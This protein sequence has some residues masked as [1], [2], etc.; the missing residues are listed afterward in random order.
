MVAV[1]RTLADLK[2]LPSRSVDELIR[3]YG[4][5]RRTE[6]RLQAM[7]DQQQHNLPEDEMQRAC[8]ALAMDC[9]DWKAFYR[10]LNRYRR[11]VE[12]HFQQVFASPQAEKPPATDPL[13]EL[14]QERLST[15]EEIRL[16]KIN[17]TRKK[18]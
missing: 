15:E 13:V 18:G 10:E 14:W 7:H 9:P 4:F 11:Q 5:L 6:N 2:L 16:I 3:A 12:T 1:L 8:L 17:M